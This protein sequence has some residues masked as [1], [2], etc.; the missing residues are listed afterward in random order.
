MSCVTIIAANI[1]AEVTGKSSTELAIDESK[2]GNIA[3]TASH[4]YRQRTLSID[5][6]AKI[7]ADTHANS[8][9]ILTRHAKLFLYNKV[10]SQE[11]YQR[12]AKQSER[13][14]QGL[15]RAAKSLQDS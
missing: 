11:R 15:R 5:E 14:A 13:I 12:K 6:K 9:N 8:A 7:L 10:S 4:L 1:Q 2:Q 3:S